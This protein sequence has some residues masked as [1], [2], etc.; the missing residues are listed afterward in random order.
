MSY[1]KKIEK[2]YNDNLIS[3]K[4]TSELRGKYLALSEEER[5][6]LDYK[7][8]SEEEKTLLIKTPSE[9][10]TNSSKSPDD[11]TMYKIKFRYILLLLFIA[12]ILLLVLLI[13]LP[14][15]PIEQ[16]LPYV[17][18]APSFLMFFWIPLFLI[19]SFLRYMYKI[20]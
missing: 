19:I 18:K 12:P 5:K 3:L 9:G 10:I 17:E 1:I 11:S 7:Y 8:L 14:I 13:V 2:N 15:V 4:T 16:V 6:E 20:R